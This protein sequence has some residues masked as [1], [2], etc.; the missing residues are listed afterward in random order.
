MFGRSMPK[1][2][3]LVIYRHRTPNGAHDPL[4]VRGAINIALLTECTILYSS[5]GL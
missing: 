2:L 3:E 4:F 1:V 5:A